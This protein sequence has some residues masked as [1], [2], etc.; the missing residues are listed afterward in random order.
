MAALLRTEV[1]GQGQKHWDQLES[2]DRNLD[3]R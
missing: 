2:H 1:E 3:K